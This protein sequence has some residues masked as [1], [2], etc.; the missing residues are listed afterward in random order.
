M[1]VGSTENYQNGTERHKVSKCCWENGTNRLASC[2]VATNLQFVKKKKNSVSAKCN[3]AKHN[4]TRYLYSDP[5]QGELGSFS[6]T[7]LS[8]TRP[9]VSLLI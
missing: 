4:K 7:H 8:Y 6:A 9:I 1:K 2:T 3:K 5:F